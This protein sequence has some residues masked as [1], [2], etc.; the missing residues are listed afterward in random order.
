MDKGAER[1]ARAGKVK[2][3]EGKVPLK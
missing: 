2:G 1:E 3:R